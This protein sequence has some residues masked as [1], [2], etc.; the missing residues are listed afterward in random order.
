MMLIGKQ[1]VKLKRRGG[2]GGE[3]VGGEGDGDGLAGNREGLSILV[4][5]NLT[6]IACMVE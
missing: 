2:G 5:L 1:M 4:I 6:E 3:G